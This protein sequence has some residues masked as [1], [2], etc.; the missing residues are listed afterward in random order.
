MPT[1]AQ[2]DHLGCGQ[3]DAGWPTE[4]QSN[5]CDE[6]ARRDNEQAFLRG[7]VIASSVLL[8]LLVLGAIN[9]YSV[10]GPA[11][12]TL[13]TKGFYDIDAANMLQFIWEDHQH[14]MLDAVMLCMLTIGCTPAV[15]VQRTSEFTVSWS[16]L[17]Y[18]KGCVNVTA[19][20]C[21]NSQM[22]STLYKGETA[23]NQAL[24]LVTPNQPSPR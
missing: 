21:A 3:C 2:R 20:S 6:S 18:N 15:H 16:R 23:P 24:C 9:N 11:A 12:S 1:T 5:L 14:F 22:F 4:I 19:G 13:H 7:F 10:P 17:S 8:S